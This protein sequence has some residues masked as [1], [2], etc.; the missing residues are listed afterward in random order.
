[1]NTLFHDRTFNSIFII[2][3]DRSSLEDSIF[4][5]PTKYISWCQNSIG[6][7][8]PLFAEIL[9]IILGRKIVNFAGRIF[10]DEWK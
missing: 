3:I 8:R 2:L 6:E 5:R 4:P 10:K 7:K 9:Q 1:M